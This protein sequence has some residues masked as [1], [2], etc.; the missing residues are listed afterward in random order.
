M[1]Q[2][3]GRVG[4]RMQ[5]RLILRH[6]DIY[7]YIVCHEAYDV[8]MSRD[9]IIAAAKAVLDREGVAGLTI[10]KVGAHAGVS[11]MALY[12]HFPDKGALLD[13]LM[14]AGLLAWGKIVRSLRSEDPMEWLRELIEAYLNFALKHPHQFDVAFFSPA[15]GARQYPDDFVAGRSAVVA[16]IIVRIDQAKADGR[17]GDKPALEV[18]LA[19]SAL[20]QGLVSMQRANRFSSEKQFRALFR[21]ALHHC[22]D[23]FSVEALERAQ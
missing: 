9:R 7:V 17:L 16:M 10:R 8:H 23:S 15:P 5:V 4:S 6:P 21:T 2:R 1:D 3:L 19:L 14:D 12:R 20:A 13:A 18:A 11:P 22:L